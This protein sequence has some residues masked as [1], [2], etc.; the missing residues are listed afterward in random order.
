MESRFK[1]ICI[2]GA[3][4]TGKTKLAK[5]ISDIFDIPFIS[6]SSSNLWG[7]FG[8]GTHSEVHKDA[9]INPSNGMKLQ[10]KILNT[11]QEMYYNK[12]YFVTD[13]GPID[14]L[15][16][17][18]NYFQ[19]SHNAITKTAFIEKLNKQLQHFDAMIFVR[20]NQSTIENNGI[21]IVDP[22][23]QLVIDS[24]MN[25]II[26]KQLLNLKVPLI[27]LPTWNW[28][29]RV[30]DINNFICQKNKS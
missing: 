11:R 13:R 24:I 21:R 28:D 16:Y 15:A 26:D 2:S 14:H 8:Y 1:R 3:S 25:L 10:N 30:I 29:L 20:F 12:S 17:Y 7:E 19:V 4:G 27:N 5:Y 9:F 6:A 23:Y 18:L 22:Y